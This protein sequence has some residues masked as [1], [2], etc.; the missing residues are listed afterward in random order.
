[1]DHRI[2]SK[3][4]EITREALS[5]LLGGDDNE[6]RS[7]VSRG[8]MCGDECEVAAARAGDA[9]RIRSGHQAIV[10]LSPRF[11]PRERRVQDGMEQSHGRQPGRG[12]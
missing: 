6:S 2:G 8:H 4:P 11:I 1:M 5:F 7:W 10:E 3:Y 12:R 9:E